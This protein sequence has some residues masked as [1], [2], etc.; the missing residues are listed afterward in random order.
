[1]GKGSKRRPM[2]ISQAEYDKRWD[3]AFQKKPI[4]RKQSKSVILAK[5]YGGKWEY[6][7]VNTWWCDDKK[8]YVCRCAPP[9]IDDFD[10]KIGPPQY[11]LYGG[12]YPERVWF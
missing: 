3:M 8:R 6:D 10:E 9:I 4:K 2:Q 7:G 11:W 1:M 5:I 12:G